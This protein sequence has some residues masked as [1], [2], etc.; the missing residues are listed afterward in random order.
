MRRH[1]LENYGRKKIGVLRGEAEWNME[2][3]R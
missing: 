1:K 3:S 2:S